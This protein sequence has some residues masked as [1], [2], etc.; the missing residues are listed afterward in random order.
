MGTGC[1]KG[2]G[3]ALDAAEHGDHLAAARRH[4]GRRRDRRPHQHHGRPRHEDQ[5]DP[6]GRV[7][8][9]GG[10]ARGREHHLRR[11]SSTPSMGDVV[12]VTVIA[13]GF[14]LQPAHAENMAARQQ[15]RPALPVGTRA[16]AA[17]AAGV[18]AAAQQGLV[19][20]RRLAAVAPRSTADRGR[21]RRRT[22]D[23]AARSRWR[24]RLARV[25]RGGDAR[26]GHARHPGVP[27]KVA[28]RRLSAGSPP[29]RTYVELAPLLG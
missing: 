9:P 4:L 28:S 22:V 25:R 27:P 20:Q 17:V 26:R 7:A 14:D 19:A 6:G 24:S 10:G 15:R 23:V 18:R 13:T 11:W 21:G 29:S 5:G 3:R 1:A 12:K 16:P 8:R 2:E